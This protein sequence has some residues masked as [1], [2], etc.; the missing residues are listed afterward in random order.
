MSKQ[1]GGCFQIFA[2]FSQYLNFKYEN[3]GHTGALKSMIL[4][5]LW[6]KYISTKC[7]MRGPNW[8][9]GVIRPNQRSLSNLTC[10]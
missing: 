8:N 2:A 3:T 5:P 6:L 1:R 9:D 10:L 7:S 4:N